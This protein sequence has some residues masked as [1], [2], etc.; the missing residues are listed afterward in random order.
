MPTSIRV[1]KHPFLHVEIRDVKASQAI[2][3]LRGG[4]DDLKHI[5]WVSYAHG[6]LIAVL[7]AVLLIVS[8]SH[9]YLVAAAVT[10]YL[11]VGPVMTSGPCELSRRR[12][13]RDALGF[14]E[15][16]D[17]ITRNPEGLLHFG[18]VLATIAIVWS[19]AS[20]VILQSLPHLSSLSLNGVLWGSFT[21]SVSRPQLIAYASCGAVLAIIVFTL[22]VVAIPLI[23]DRHATAAEAMWA[24]LRCT[25]RN[26]PAM[27]VWS[28]LIVGLTA[29]G[30]ATMLLGMIVVAPLLGHA[31]WHAY[32]DL[33]R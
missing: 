12:A 5:G 15:S 18:A 17:A 19:V 7:G 3:W 8:S 25:F 20:G 16:L 33:V 6:V 11:L 13:A 27:L 28:A 22:S 23:I 10:G 4:W 24:S 14:D 2:A 31:T 32:R 26:L 21:D 30:F 29:V 9:L 1:E